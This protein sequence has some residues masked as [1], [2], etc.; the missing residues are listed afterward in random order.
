[1][2]KYLNKNL[3]IAIIGGGP[4]GLSLGKLLNIKGF[5][6]VS[7]YEREK[8]RDYRIQGS[9]LDLHPD[10]GLKVIK[11]CGLYDQFK[12][13][14]RPEGEYFTLMKKNGSI[15]F[16]LPP[17]DM[18]SQYHLGFSK[19]EIDRGQLRDLFLDSFIGNESNN[20]NINIKWNYHFESLKFDNLNNN[21]KLKFFN[22]DL[23][24]ADLVIGCD[25]SNSKVRKYVTNLE[26][27]YSGVTLIT[28]E[29]ENAKNT[30]P[31]LYNLVNGGLLFVVGDNQGFMSQLKSDGSLTIYYS[32][33]RSWDWV[34]DQKLKFQNDS[35]SLLNFTNDQLKD[36]N[37]LVKESFR[38]CNLDSIV[39]RP[40]FN[41]PY[42]KRWKSL[43]PGITLI[44][45][46]SHVM[47][48]F[49]GVG[50]NLAMYDSL[51]L[52][53]EL[54]N[55]HHK[56]LF[57]A[58]ES[59]ESKMFDSSFW[60]MNNTKVAQDSIHSERVVD[61]LKSK[62]IGSNDLLVWLKLNFINSLNSCT[63]FLHL[64]K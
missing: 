1:M 30:F 50:L 14:S 28:G 39:F 59:F 29:I 16:K 13:V 43:T 64:T 46:A 37:D 24:D 62:L 12:K 6:N 35:I 10:T 2:S 27:E 51:L 55:P 11:E 57:E 34:R 25:G 33:E 56:F 19:P 32:S 26:M 36:W 58:L 20:N 31:S 47:P 17:I 52:V 53:N 45:D 8:S 44:G 41:A 15:E 54:T 7:I 63:K 18:I 4:G 61:F 40:L 9:S 38:F 49:S 42:E 3:K 21:F 48:P 23:I 22:T 60:W 5:N